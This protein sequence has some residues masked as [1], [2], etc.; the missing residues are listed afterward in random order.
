MLRPGGFAVLGAVAQ[1]GT[2]PSWPKP[3]QS[4]VWV[5]GRRGIWRAGNSGEP[6]TFCAGQGLPAP[7]SPREGPSQAPGLAFHRTKMTP[8]SQPPPAEQASMSSSP[9][10]TGEALGSCV[11]VSVRSNPTTDKLA[12][13]IEQPPSSV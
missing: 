7:S 11:Q 1:Q 10:G 6:Q 2:S 13:K 8:Y 5:P 3:E 12:A 4:R 9:T